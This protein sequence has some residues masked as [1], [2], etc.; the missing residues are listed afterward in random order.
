[1]SR[2]GRTFLFTFAPVAALVGWLVLAGMP[3]PAMVLGAMGLVLHWMFSRTGGSYDGEVADASYFY[4]FLLTLV[5]LAAGLHRLGLL[6]SGSSDASV[7]VFG[8]L[9][10]LAAGLSLTVLGL[11]IRQV[12][13]LDAGPAAHGTAEDRLLET[14]ARLLAN[15][16]TLVAL[17]RERPEQAVI[18]DL[19]D[20]RASARVAAQNL[21]RD[22]ARMTKAVKQLEDAAV[23]ASQSITIAATGAG[24]ALS[25]SSQLLQANLTSVMDG[26]RI[27]VGDAVGQIHSTVEHAL[28]ALEHHRAETASAL[29]VAR[30]ANAEARAAADAHLQ[31]HVAAW[32]MSLEQA[33]SALAQVQQSMD[34]EYRRGLQGFAEAGVAFATLAGN[35]ATQ[36]Q[37]LPDPAER[38]AGLWE[39]VRALEQGLTAAVEGASRE[40]YS[41]QERAGILSA[42]LEQLGGST[43][44]AARSVD[45]GGTELGES[46]QRELAQMNAIIDQYVTLLERT[47]RTMK[48]RA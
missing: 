12:R 6:S 30:S 16:E 43:R 48:V 47:T 33:R 36:V 25:E 7:A 32:T 20:T 15:M 22:V 42:E 11:V 40:L 37:S 45:T 24:A 8:F 35:V 26:L 18:Q 44:A 1:M 21:G 28:A 13:T 17:W 46:L 4:G 2:N 14:Q 29:E 19:T 23:G 3:F 9:E 5:F 39:G 41:L 38:L 10:D 27:G 34:E 31:E